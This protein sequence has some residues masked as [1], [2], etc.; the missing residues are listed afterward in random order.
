V[1]SFVER[2]KQRKVVRWA[3]AYLAGAWFAVEVVGQL[4]ELFAIP[5]GVQRGLV[6]VLAFGLVAVVALAWFHGEEG[7]QR[8]T[9]A[10]LLVMAV[11]VGLA[12]A[13]LAFLGRRT[14]S[15][16]PPSVDAVPGGVVGPR[17]PSSVAI[18]P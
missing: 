9:G 4:G 3:L 15:A 1:S 10:E 18:L 12:G 13:T 14:E 2:L 16:S 8:V 17:T 6:T 7:R 11:V 5:L